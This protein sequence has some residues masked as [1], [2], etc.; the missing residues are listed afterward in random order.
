MTFFLYDRRY[1]KS[2]LRQVCWG[3][4]K[5]T[6]YSRHNWTGMQDRTV[7]NPFNT[8]HPALLS[9]SHFD[10]NEQQPEKPVL[11]V[12]SNLVAQLEGYWKAEALSARDQRFVFVFSPFSSRHFIHTEPSTSFVARSHSVYVAELLF[13]KIRGTN[14]RLSPHCYCTR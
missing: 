4:K 6:P 1:S 9:R 11:V 12:R 3:K 14:F 5:K 10:F 7:N 2:S 13:S 8:Y